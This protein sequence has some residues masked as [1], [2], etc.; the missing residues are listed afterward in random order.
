[1][2]K[3]NRRRFIT[4][5]RIAIVGI[6]GVA[7]ILL[8]GI[9]LTP[10]EID[11]L[12]ASQVERESEA[13]RSSEGSRSVTCYADCQVTFGPRSVNQGDE[14]KPANQEAERGNY[15]SNGISLADY[16]QQRRMAHWT[17]V[18]AALTAWGA[19]LL[20]G[21]LYEAFVGTEAAGKAVDAQISSERPII[22]VDNLS[23]ER[24][25]QIPVDESEQLLFQ[26][27]WALKNYGKTACWLQRVSFNA[28]I[29]VEPPPFPNESE[30][31][32]ENQAAFLGPTGG[33]RNEKNFVPN[34]TIEGQAL[35][36]WQPALQIIKSGS[37]FFPAFAPRFYIY[38]FSEYRDTSG[39]IW[40]THFIFEVFFNKTL[41][42]QHYQ[43]VASEAHWKDYY[44]DPE[45]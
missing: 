13:Q 17:V 36:D 28:H 19:L 39:L 7:I 1:M 22:Q 42:S 2:S 43:P 25:T 44:R 21:T 35:K 10:K 12:A 5:K 18:I 16:S 14:E 4:G 15:T 3:R 29:G 27:S 20:V 37:K 45:E 34:V 32:M 11:P 38:G 30:W 26:F 8:F 40:N 24:N 33:I 41:S 9:G 23:L 31:K 6:A